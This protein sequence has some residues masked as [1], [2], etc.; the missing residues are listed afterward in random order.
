MYVYKAKL[1]KIKEWG[2]N[3]TELKKTALLY[4]EQTNV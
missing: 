2:P 4:L 3:E 1:K